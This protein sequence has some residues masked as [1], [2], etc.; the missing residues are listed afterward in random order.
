MLDGQL[1]IAF[2]SNPSEIWQHRVRQKAWIA[3][4]V[5]RH[6]VDEGAVV[7]EKS[8]HQPLQLE[9]AVDVGQG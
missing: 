9:S 2:A 4:T 5:T 1:L 7:L 8:L 3:P 6:R